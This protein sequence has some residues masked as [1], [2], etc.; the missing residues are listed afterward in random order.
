MLIG[1]SPSVVGSLPLRLNAFFC[2]SGRTDRSYHESTINLPDRKLADWQIRMYRSGMPK[3]P[4]PRETATE[5]LG[6]PVEMWIDRWRT[7][8]ARLSYTQIARMLTAEHGVYVEP[9][10]VRAWHNSLTDRNSTEPGEKS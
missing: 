1:P 3:H 6:E 9:E 10:T 7:S 4:S 8:P 2:W 5:R